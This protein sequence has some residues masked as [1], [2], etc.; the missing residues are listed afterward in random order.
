MRSMLFPLLAALPAGIAVGADPV[1]VTETVEINAPASQVWEAMKHFDGL[2]TWHPAVANTEITEGE[3]NTVGAVRKLTLGDGG[4]IMETL[5]AHDDGAM[6]FSY[7]MGE[8][9]LPVADYTSTKTVSGDHSS[10]QVTWSGRFQPTTEDAAAVIS[11]VYRAGLD[12][13][14][15]QLEAN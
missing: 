13:L 11:T 9:V 10:A 4:V 5:E 3:S 1:E 2:H 8:T 6:S 14:K 7:S 12:N 15:T